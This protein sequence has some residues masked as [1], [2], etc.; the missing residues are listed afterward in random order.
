MQTNTPFIRIREVMMGDSSTVPMEQDLSP[1]GDRTRSVTPEIFARYSIEN[2]GL[3]R[4][5]RYCDMLKAFGYNSIQLCDTW[6]N[7][8]DA[9][10]GFHP[11]GRWPKA[12]EDGHIAEARDWPAKVDALADYARSIGLRTTIFV[13][14][15]TPFDYRTGKIYWT[16]CPNDATEREILEQ[17][18][19]HQARHAEHFDHFVTHWGD[20]G[21]CSRNGCDITTAQR[22]H[23]DLLGRF[24]R[25]N[26][27]IQSSFSLWMLAD[28]RFGKWPGYKG[29]RTVAAGGILPDDVMLSVHAEHRVFNEKEV[30]EI[31]AHG[32]R[33]GVW[34]WYLVNNEIIPSMYG[35]T[36]ALKEFFD[37]LPADATDLI[38][39]QSI[40]NNNHI[41]NLDSLYICA[42]QMLD[43]TADPVAAQREFLSGALGDAS[44]AD[45]QFVLQAIET[46][47]PMWGYK[48]GDEALDVGLA[49]QAEAVARSISATDDFVPAF[50]MPLTPA[51]YSQELVAQAEALREFAEFSVAA[52]EVEKMVKAGAPATVVDAA[53]NSLPAV[54]KPT[55]W[56]TNLEWCRRLA[57]IA[58]LR[59]GWRQGPKTF[60]AAGQQ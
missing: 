18:W 16:A 58:A 28:P 26:P 27:R 60:H 25:L 22:I 39:W 23:V 41:L 38:A 15:N 55:R 8:L 34:T 3:P 14:G 37:A 54:K 33:A 29:V 7:Y 44:A 17:H 5:K 40:D 6:E 59:E 49:R 42:K 45:A 20:P 57:R 47:R 12:Y 1:M 53:L 50:P 51:E 21:G 24:R 43:R 9:G 4:L 13:W 30:R 52:A 10:W 19:E 36:R 46:L 11:D 35:R 2:W 48:Y 56:M 32:R 31:V